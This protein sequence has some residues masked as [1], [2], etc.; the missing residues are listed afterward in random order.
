MP[1]KKILITVDLVVYWVTYFNNKIIYETQLHI[2]KSSSLML[3]QI[4]TIGLGT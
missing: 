4:S 1:Y 2:K 3:Q